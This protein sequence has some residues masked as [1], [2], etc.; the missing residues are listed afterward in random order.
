MVKGSLGPVVMWGGI[1][2]GSTS[3]DIAHEV[4]KKTLTLL[5]KNGVDGAIVEWPEAVP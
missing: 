4:S 2:P 5:W 1:I 3:A